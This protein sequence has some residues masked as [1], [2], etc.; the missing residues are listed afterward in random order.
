LHASFFL[1]ESQV[2]AASSYNSASK[3]DLCKFFRCLQLSILQQLENHEGI[4]K[5]QKLMQRETSQV[6]SFQ[7]FSHRDLFINLI[8]REYSQALQFHN[9][10]KASPQNQTSIIRGLPVF[11]QPQRS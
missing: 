5:V 7:V 2:P 6:F 10:V 3:T 4:S 9:I 1:Q 11:P 8:Y